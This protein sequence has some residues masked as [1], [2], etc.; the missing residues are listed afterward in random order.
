MIGGAIRYNKQKSVTENFR[1]PIKILYKEDKKKRNLSNK[2]ETLRWWFTD[3]AWRYGWRDSK[4]SD[5]ILAHKAEIK[6]ENGNVLITIYHSP[7]SKGL[8]DANVWIETDA[9]IDI[10]NEMVFLN[11]DGEY[12]DKF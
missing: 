7:A 9:E 8:C 5:D 10:S 6:D 12:I 11:D 1:P 4:S 2:P 3:G